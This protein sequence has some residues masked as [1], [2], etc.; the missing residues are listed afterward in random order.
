MAFTTL[1]PLVSG[2]VP[3]AA[4]F[5]AYRDNL[6][7][8]RN[9]GDHYCRL[10]LTSNPSV[11]DNVSTGQAINWQASSFQVGSIWNPAQGNR[12]TA[13]TDGIYL[14]LCVLE[15]RKN[16]N[17]LRNMNFQ[18][19]SS[20]GALIR[21]FDSQSQGAS[22][23]KSNI[24]GKL[25]VKMTAGQFIECRA[26]QNSGGP[27]TLHGGSDDRTRVAVLFLGPVGS[28]AF[29][30]PTS[31][32]I[33]VNPSHTQLNQDLITNPT[34]LRQLNGTA[35]RVHKTSVQSLTSGART[36]L[37]WQAQTYQ[38]GITWSA[39]ANPTR[40]TVSITG[41]YLIVA[42]VPIAN[43]AGDVRG[44]GYRINGL[45]TAWDLQFHP[46]NGIDTLCGLGFAELRAGDYVEV[47][48]YQNTG[49]VNTR[50]TDE[51][52][53]WAHL[54]L[55]ATGNRMQA[56]RWVKPY[57]WRD[58]ERTPAARFQTHLHDQLLSLR[59]M[60]SAGASVWL[61]KD[62]SISPDARGVISWDRAIRNVGGMW[63]G[64]SK[65][66]APVDG[67]YFFNLDAEWADS[68]QGAAEG[69]VQG[70][71][72]A[73]NGGATG[74]RIQFQESIVDRENQSG[75]DLIYLLKGDY[76]EA[77]ASQDSSESLSINGGGPDATRC[78]VTLWAASR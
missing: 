78:T 53:C 38:N 14:F 50:G 29:T 25:V 54:S 59:N 33:I 46:G 5:N 56:P 42:N 55:F 15:W 26:Y 74:H 57:T 76:V 16:S 21:Q 22:G 8:V 58:G 31:W 47:Y 69:A 6:L 36:A 41:L 35:I 13:P 20:A 51:G 12:L 7:S 24:N 1:T 18:L 34:S 2:S 32:P 72:Y 64:S 27:L 19:K 63:D 43:V 11:G 39:G 37:I 62:Q 30:A 17:N 75:A 44:V 9:G 49:T 71:G 77:F 48:A 3:P 73:V 10:Y 66:I 68:G 28:T 4:F 67:A 23:G 70:I 61:S 45:S 40:L 52:Q 65:F 60:K